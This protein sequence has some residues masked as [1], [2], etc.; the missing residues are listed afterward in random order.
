[1]I[2]SCQFAMLHRT[3]WQAPAQHMLFLNGSCSLSPK[4]Q[5][6]LFFSYDSAI[7]H[8]QV[9]NYLLNYSLAGHIEKI[10]HMPGFS[11]WIMFS[12]PR[13][14]LIHSLDTDKAYILKSALKKPIVKLLFSAY[15]DIFKISHNLNSCLFS[16]KILTLN[17]Q[18]L[19]FL[20]AKMSSK[21]LNVTSK[22]FFSSH[23]PGQN[24]LTSKGAEELIY[25]MK[26]AGL[27]WMCN[28]ISP[29]CSDSKID[30]DV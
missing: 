23:S 18:Q 3:Q 28:L 26:E 14:K 22:C 10:H 16:W 1:M 21:F 17:F 13:V 5:Y 27:E 24:A 9:V 15:S 30:V 25:Y 19:H 20:L 6:Y 8:G 7:A 4:R 11:N 29:Q 2:Y 12:N